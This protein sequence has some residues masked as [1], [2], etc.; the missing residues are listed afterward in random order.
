MLK[1][2]FTPSFVRDKKRCIKKHWDT[3]KLDEA[4]FAVVRSDECPIP[5]SYNNHALKGGWQGYLE[6][7]VDGRKS[8]WLLVYKLSET[9]A[10]FVRTG[11]HDDL[12]K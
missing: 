6:L 2:D 3:A 9:T 12:F 10:T 1:P 5:D 7:H 4:M 8:D 11:S